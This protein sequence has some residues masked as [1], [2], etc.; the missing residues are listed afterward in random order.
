MGVGES[1]L[2]V[3]YAMAENVFAVSQTTVGGIVR[4]GRS[5]E[6]RAFL[7]CGRPIPDVDIEIRA[8]DGRPVGPGEPGEIC[9]RSTTLFEGYFRQPAI[10]A[11]RVRDGW[12]HTND[13]GCVE[14]GELFV[15][16]RVDDLLI[17]NGKNLF[18]HEIEEV[19]TGLAG[20][21]P[22]RVLACTDFEPALGA[23]R[24]ADPRRATP[25]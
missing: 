23:T 22:G 18:A 1:K 11:E 8:A 19:L 2:Q 25:G 14:S 5:A 3:S 6:T 10:T 13:L 9:I 16:G 24:P 17:I 21:A 4:N 7:S 12:F 15:L 20:I